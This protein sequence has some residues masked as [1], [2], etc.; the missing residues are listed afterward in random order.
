MITVKFANVL[1]R[2]TGVIKQKKNNSATL[3]LQFSAHISHSF[4]VVLL[5]LVFGYSS[6]FLEE[7]KAVSG[8]LTEPSK[9]FSRNL[10]VSHLWVVKSIRN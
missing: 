9:N 3:I 7:P 1:K 6:V 4:L 8:S 5:F 10:S 2:G